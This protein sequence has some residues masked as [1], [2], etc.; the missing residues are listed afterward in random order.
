M[1]AGSS[2]RRRSPRVGDR[3]QARRK[4]LA[5][6]GQQLADKAKVSVDTVR[7]IESGRVPNPGI[8]TVAK[9]AGVLDTTLDDLAGRR[10]RKEP[11]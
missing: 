1:A 6:S 7:S 4:A 5:L 2:G 10:A 3:I 9:L 11:K 8:L